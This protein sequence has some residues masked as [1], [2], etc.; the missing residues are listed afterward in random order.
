VAGATLGAVKPGEPD[1]LWLLRYQNGVLLRSQAREC[2]ISAKGLQHRL[3]PGGPWQRLLPGVYLA[4]TGQPTWDQ[5]QTAA[6]LYAGP[7][8]AITGLAALRNHRVRGAEPRAVDVLVP[9]ERR[10]ASR[11]IAVLHRTRRMPRE[12]Y[13]DGVLRFAPPARAAVD[14]ARG[15]SQL[16]EVRAIVAGAV[17]QRKCSV[18]QLVAEVRDGPMRGSAQVRAVLAEVLAGI[19][20][21]PEAELRRLILKA[22]LPQ[23]FYNPTLL[24]GTAFLAKPDAWWP[25]AGVAV[26]VDSK[27]WHLLPADWEATMARH[28]RM[29]AAG[30]NVV[31]LSPARIRDKPAEVLATIAGALRTGRPLPHITTRP[32]A[33]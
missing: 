19:R 3:R 12:L 23:P 14:A 16:S 21:V 15:M 10:R 13:C 5:W 18:E 22:G 6:V 7:D 11:G 33:A 17:Q 28:D 8:A 27:E 25:D 32:L 30:I 1:G 4:A 2:G 31:H 9:A 29:A 26:E 20:S 24:L